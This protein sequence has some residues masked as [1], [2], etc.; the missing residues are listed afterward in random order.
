MINGKVWGNTRALLQNALVE[1]HRIEIKADGFC[2]LHKHQYKW[3]A[4]YVVS[5]E[6]EIEVH[7]NDY[8]LIDRTILTPGDFMTVKPGEYHRFHAG[9][10]TVAFE[11]Y[12]PELLSSD[13]VRR[14]VGGEKKMTT[15][16]VT[17]INGV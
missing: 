9:P 14:D 8:N 2:S 3:N 13:I 1:F 11:L 16:G 12:W 5:G 7:K 17:K 10:D 15:T 4:F 6:L